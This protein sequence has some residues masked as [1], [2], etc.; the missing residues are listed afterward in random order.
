MLVETA[1]FSS[2]K[3][4]ELIL[5]CE[6]RS[7]PVGF[8]VKKVAGGSSAYPPSQT[9]PQKALLHIPNCK[10]CLYIYESVQIFNLLTC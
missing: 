3:R 2:S 7:F 10:G 5:F 1:F 9:A 4:G 6:P 8:P